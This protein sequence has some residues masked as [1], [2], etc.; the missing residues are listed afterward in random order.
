MD[1]DS[2]EDPVD[3]DDG[4][5]TPGH[6]AYGKFDVPAGPVEITPIKS[7]PPGTDCTFTPTASSIQN[8]F[9]NLKDVKLVLEQSLM[10]TRA[11]LSRGDVIR[12]W[13][14]GVSFDLI[15]SKVSPVQYGVVS[16][17]N[18]DL[19]VDIGPPEGM[20]SAEAERLLDEGKANE[21]TGRM[22]SEPSK[23]MNQSRY[24]PS[25]VISN[26]MELPPEP[27]D[28][29]STGVCVVQIRGRESTSS[30]RRR[31]RV[32]TATMRDLFVFASHIGGEGDKDLTA[33]CLVTRFPRK[34]Y[35][36]SSS[37]GGDCYKADDT[38]SDAGIVE[39]QV[40]LMIEQV[41]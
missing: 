13:R 19:N 20:E 1:T 14:R 16:C 23:H 15:V 31:F 37:G 2:R 8:G 38:L 39:G 24:T 4:E 7:L 18:T 40:L 30:G 27:A 29:E 6:P 5:K 9:Y 36:L 33:F 21:T 12:T 34:V 28:D 22:L 17:V 41:T 11:T 26:S 10:R 32:T 25:D 3:P 35:K